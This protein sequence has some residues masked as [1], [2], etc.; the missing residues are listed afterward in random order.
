MTGTGIAEI[1][2][3][4]M[5]LRS[6][7]SM[8]VQTSQDVL[9]TAL[10]N[11]DEI[12]EKLAYEIEEEFINRPYTI[13]L[14][15]DMWGPWFGMDRSLTLRTTTINMALLYSR[16]NVAIIIIDRGANLLLT[17]QYGNTPLHI[18]AGQGLNI[19]VIKLL[20]KIRMTNPQALDLQNKAGKTPLHFAAD[21]EWEDVIKTLLVGGANP[22]I[23][24][25]FGNTPLHLA[26]QR[27]LSGQII[28][29]IIEA[30]KAKAVDDLGH[31]EMT[32]PS[33]CSSGTM[34]H[35]GLDPNAIGEAI[36]EV[37]NLR[38]N[39][40]CTAFWMAVRHQRCDIAN[41]LFKNGADPNKSDDCGDSPFHTSL[42]TD[43]TDEMIILMIEN[44]DVNHVNRDGSTL[45]RNA[46]I[47]KREVLVKYLLKR[48]ADP[49]ISDSNGNSALHLAITCELSVQ[50]I[51]D[52]LEA[53]RPKP[54]HLVY[55][56]PMTKR[57]YTCLIQQLLD[58][59]NPDII[60]KILNLSCDAIINSTNRNGKTAF[61]L[62]V[63]FDRLI[64]SSVWLPQIL[65]ENGADP[66]IADDHRDTPLHS[67]LLTQTD[68]S[69]LSMTH[70]IDVNHRYNDGSTLFH[71]AIKCSREVVVMNMLKRGANPSIANADGNT[72]L[73][74]AILHNLSSETIISIFEEATPRPAD[75]VGQ[76]GMRDPSVYLNWKLSDAPLDP[77]VNRQST[78]EII[79]FRNKLCQTALF[80]AF[81]RDRLD[82][83]QILMDRGADPNIPDN[84]GKYWTP[85]TAPGDTS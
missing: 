78:S 28:I 18:A 7:V 1:V 8:I 60:S 62:A 31:N 63:L 73:H 58:R 14:S 69:I 11:G 10:E 4:M 70:N 55:Q 17:D 13:P 34:V 45:L 5:I 81:T 12:A 37:M 9:H 15:D 19:A 82:I 30:M 20:K 68:D 21:Y 25:S 44:I 26:I 56:N 35:D 61:F 52:I 41:I 39:L 16:E 51:M 54:I 27:N 3:M 42:P 38:N 24:D 83:A 49:F 75:I 67:I 36:S 66:T 76:N 59:L 65:L 85:E 74:L 40:G 46:I 57:F 71:C 50:I 72:A 77:N 79:N 29:D 22:N 6:G 32:N 2:L 33:G 84:R 23:A 47:Y 48:G 53:A 64:K 80:L 43:M